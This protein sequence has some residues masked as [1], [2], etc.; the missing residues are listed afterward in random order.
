MNWPKGHGDCGK[1]SQQRTEGE[2]FGVARAKGQETAEKMLMTRRAEA[3][4]RI[5]T[6]R[7]C[8]MSRLKKGLTATYYAD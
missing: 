2:H 4:R 5:A 6:S 1:G 8:D 3:T 7:N